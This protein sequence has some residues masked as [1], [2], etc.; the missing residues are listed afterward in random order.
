M[1]V[2]GFTETW[3]NNQIPNNLLVIPGF[4]MVRND[5]NYSRGGTSLYIC[6]GVNFVNNESISNNHIEL[7]SITLTGARG[8]QTLKSIIFVLIYRPPK[9]NDSTCLDFIMSYLSRIPGIEN[10]DLLIIG[11]LNWDI[12][13]EDS[14]G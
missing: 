7:Q 9:G 6:H 12:G 11:D 3:L 8:N 13:V 5:R 4:N 10:M 2:I 1:D 14:S